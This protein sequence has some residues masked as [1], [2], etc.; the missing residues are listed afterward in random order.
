[1]QRSLDKRLVILVESPEDCGVIDPHLNDSEVQTSPGYGMESVL[2][3]AQ[4]FWDNQ[5][6]EVIAVVDADLDRYTGR[7]HSSNVVMTEFYDLDADVLF[8]CP[9]ALNPILANFT[10]K[11][12]RQPYLASRGTSAYDI[13]WEMAIAVGEVRYYSI[14][15]QCGFNIRGFPL[16]DVVKGYERADT[17]A[18]VVAVALIRTPSAASITASD[19][20]AEV[21]A[22]PDKK[23][24]ASGHDLMSA[25]A[26][27]SRMRWGSTAGATMLASALRI[28]TQCPCWKQ[29]IV[30]SFVQQWASQFTVKAWTCP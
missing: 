7:Q 25:L 17:L 20:A 6:G 15:Q 12:L 21:A 19:V 3:A 13:I 24:V 10:D 27:L 14:M 23:Y 30:Y 29:T 4:I 11:T 2:V 28:A 8:H 1:M 18:S 9:Q 26:T 5:I 22:L 16:A